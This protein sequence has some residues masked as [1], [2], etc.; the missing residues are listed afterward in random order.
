MFDGLKFYF[1]QKKGIYF[2]SRNKK[3]DLELDELG[4]LILGGILLLLLIYIITV[5]LKGEF[6]SQK[7]DVKSIFDIFK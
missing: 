1:R 2:L 3:G 5:F 7:D 4:K 6:G